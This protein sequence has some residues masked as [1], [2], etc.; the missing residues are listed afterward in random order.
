VLA[1]RL[2]GREGEARTALA[3]FIACCSFMHAWGIALTFDNAGERDKAFEWLERARVNMDGG[4]R[5]LKQSP[6]FKGDPRTSAILR[7]MNLPVD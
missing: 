3:E 2:L 5:N 4:I 1:L 6:R 7:K